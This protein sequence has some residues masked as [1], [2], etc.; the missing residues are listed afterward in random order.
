[1]NQVGTVK[2]FQ[3]TYTVKYAVFNI[4]CAWDSVKAKTLHQAWGKLWPATR[5]AEGASDE[6]DFEGFNVCNKDTFHEMV[7]MSENWT[8]QTPN[9]KSGRYGRLDRCR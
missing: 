2:D 1:V 3:H 8:L 6:D 4:A 7:L 9:V 5:V